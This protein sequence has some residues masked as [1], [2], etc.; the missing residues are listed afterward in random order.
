MIWRLSL[1]EGEAG[2]VRQGDAV[3]GPELPEGLPAAPAH[4]CSPRPELWSRPLSRFRLEPALEHLYLSD[5]ACHC[6][7]A[8]ELHLCLSE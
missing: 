7:F 4:L 3:P 5:Q 1:R 8:N 2:G 6:D